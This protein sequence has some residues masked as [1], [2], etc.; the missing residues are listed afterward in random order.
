MSTD[1]TQ[2]TNGDLSG[3]EENI[4]VTGGSGLVGA[5]LIAQLLAD[6]ARVTAIYNK[7]PLPYPEN[8]NLTRV[9]CDILD[10]AM[11]E[12]AM[13]GI[14]KVYH[15]AAVVSFNKKSRDYLYSVNVNGTANVVNAAI[16]AGVKKMVHVSSVSALGRLREGQNVTEDMQWSRESNSSEY[17]R[18]KFLSEMEVWRGTGEGLDAVIVNP[19]LILGGG[20]WTKSSTA[21]FKTA[22]EEFPWYTDGITGFVDVRDVAKAMIQLMNSKI[23]NQRFII[24]GEN[25][26]YKNVFTGIAHCFGKKPPHKKVSPFVAELVWRLAAVKSYFNREE[27]LLT[28]ETARTAQTKIYFDSTKLKE[29]LP[30]FTFTSIKDAIINAC[31][32]MKRSYDL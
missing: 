26:S 5:E 31:T 19:S 7:T 23:V 15:C 25:A 16:N 1:H 13:K 4:L 28:R 12:V 8:K 11:L 14:S 29:A 3:E 30:G 18:S 24:N 22:Y 20:D 17:G 6:K 21:I 9:K 27:Q 10:S 2:K 32:T